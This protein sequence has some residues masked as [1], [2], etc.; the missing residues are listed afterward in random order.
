MKIEIRQRDRRALFGLAFALAAYGLMKLVALPAYDRLAVA[1]DAVSQKE[2]QLRRYR[3]AEMRKG[4]Y[5]DLL[6][7]TTA[8]I[9]ENETVVAVVANDAAISTNLQSIVEASARKVGV[10]FSQRT[11]GGSRK[12][13]EFY[14]EL[15]L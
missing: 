8:K 7:L 10:M 3:R 4:Q 6:K 1:A 13:N 12:L 14:S 2:T 9:V 11:V 5:E 15:T